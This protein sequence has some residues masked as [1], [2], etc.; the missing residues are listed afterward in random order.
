[1]DMGN[2]KWAI[3]QDEDGGED[4]NDAEKERKRGKGDYTST[5]DGVEGRR[6]GEPQVA[7]LPGSKG[8]RKCGKWP[9]Y[10]TR[11]RREVK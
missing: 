8:G 9:A 5:D 6:K 4:E 7:R 2:S 10:A 11:E 1:M 3:R